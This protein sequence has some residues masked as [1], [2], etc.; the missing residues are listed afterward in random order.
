MIGDVAGPA[1]PCLAALDT[2]PEGAAQPL[3]PERLNWSTTMSANTSAE[4]LRWMIA[5]A[6]SVS[7]GYGTERIGPLRV[8][9][10]TGWSSI[11]QSMR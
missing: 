6:S 10:H 2:V 9:S 4:Y 1:Q 7:I 5:C 8:R 11:G 3:D